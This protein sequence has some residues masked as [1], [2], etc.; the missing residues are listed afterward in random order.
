MNR[1]L[2]RSHPSAVIVILP[3]RATPTHWSSTARQLL[4]QASNIC[5]NDRIRTC[6]LTR[7]TLA[8]AALPYSFILP[9]GTANAGRY[10]HNSELGPLNRG[11]ATRCSKGQYSLT[12][13]AQLAA[14]AADLDPDC[15][16]QLTIYLSRRLGH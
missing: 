15:Y 3:I 9:A 4:D 13:T 6:Y 7:T 12:K 8:H 2:G 1:I 14:G 5:D 10:V 11:T 16:R